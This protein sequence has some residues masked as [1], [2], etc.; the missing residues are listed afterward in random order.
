MQYLTPFIYKEV[1]NEVS[2]KDS[3]P[4]I[5]AAIFSWIYTVFTTT[6]DDFKDNIKFINLYSFPGDKVKKCSQ[7]IKKKYKNLQGTGYYD[8]NIL[9]SILKVFKQ[10]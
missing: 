7:D 1:M 2:T 9:V 5:L 6:M 10:S 4:E 8:P 3:F